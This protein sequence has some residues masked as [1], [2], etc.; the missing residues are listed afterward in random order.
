VFENGAVVE[1]DSLQRPLFVFLNCSS[2]GISGSPVLRFVGKT[3]VRNKDSLRTVLGGLGFQQDY[4]FGGVYETWN[5]ILSNSSNMHF[6][7]LDIR[8]LNL[9]EESVIPIVINLKP[10]TAGLRAVGNRIDNLTINGFQHGILFYGQEGLHINGVNADYRAG[11]DEIAPGHVVYSTGTNIPAVRSRNVVIRGVTDGPNPIN[12]PASRDHNLG[13][14]AIKALEQSKI[15]KIRSYHPAGLITSIADNDRNEFEDLCWTSNNHSPIVGSAIYIVGSATNNRYRRIVILASNKYAGI[16]STSASD[17]SRSVFQDVVI[18][19]ADPSPVDRVNP[20]IHLFG[21]D[22][23]R[24][25]VMFRALTN[26]R[27]S[28]E[29]FHVI[30]I[31]QVISNKKALASI[32]QTIQLFHGLPGSLGEDTGVAR[33]ISRKA[34]S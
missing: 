26:Q 6:D 1:F 33:Y 7:N 34:C 9:S 17:S 20:L 3:P 32:S 22:I 15:E 18:S 23:T 10:K 8:S 12:W 14:L 16:V 27:H 28:L 4:S 24:T 25:N 2:G 13:T 31:R 19:S 21:E 29:Q 5:V 11:L 30:P